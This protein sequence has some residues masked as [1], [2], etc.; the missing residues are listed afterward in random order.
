MPRISE[1]QSAVSRFRPRA[2]MARTKRDLQRGLVTHVVEG[3][4]RF[5]LALRR[6]AFNNSALTG[7][8][9]ILA[10]KVALRPTEVT[11]QDIAAAKASGLSEDELFELVVCAAVGQASR[12]DEAALR[13]L[14]QALPEREKTTVRLRILNT[15]Y[16]L[17]TKVLFAIVRLVSGSAMPDAARI[18]FYRSEFYGNAFRELTQEAVRGTSEWSVGERELMAA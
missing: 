13:A 16:A 11:D 5:T 18:V 15:C 17:G 6:A 14:V 12:Q 7:P 10:G 2:E 1:K 3:D 4:L 8:I 9:A